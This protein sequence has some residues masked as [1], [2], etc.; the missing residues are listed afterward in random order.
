MP[1][2]PSAE[3]RRLEVVSEGLRLAVWRSGDIGPPVVFVH[4]YPDTHAVWDRVVQRLAGRFR[5]VSYDVR[6]A[7]ASDAPGGREGYRLG[8]LVSDLV[9]VLDSQFPAEPVHLVGH[10]WGSIQAWDAVL[11]ARSY[12]RLQGR[13]VSYTT[14]SG[15]ALQ[16][17]DAY[18]GA[19]RRGNWASKRAALNQ[20]RHSW[21]VYAFQVPL[22]PEV[23][24]RG[25]LEAIMRR[26]DPARHAFASTLPSDA[27]N[28]LELYRANLF[29]GPDRVP[30]GARTT[31]PVQ[32]VVPL[33]DAFITE[34]F[35]GYASRFVSDLT[36]VEIEG[37]H[38]VALSH[39][40]ELSSAIAAFV[41]SHPATRQ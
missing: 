36:R 30:G 25:H 28:G 26:A 12:P 15:P 10:D 41:T 32:L 27:V 22:L 9:A 17:A 14:I 6:G 3:Q 4:G 5:C 2:P 7:G 40:D 20:L 21:Y 34:P 11:R 29:S 38:W 33:R 13:F 8:C 16:H 37:G 19:A 39:P 31:L 35:A 24:L 1:D 18:I 23:V